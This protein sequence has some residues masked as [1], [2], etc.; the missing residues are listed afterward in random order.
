MDAKMLAKKKRDTLPKIDDYEHKFR[1][2]DNGLNIGTLIPKE[3][4]DWYNLAVK[5][6][7]VKKMNMNSPRS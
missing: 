4:T 5:S 2:K 1:N 3:T 6:V 7:K